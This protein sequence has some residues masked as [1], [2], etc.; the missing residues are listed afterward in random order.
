MPVGGDGRALSAA[1]MCLSDNIGCTRSRP[2]RLGGR[3]GTMAWPRSRG[4]DSDDHRPP[5]QQ[6]PLAARAVAARRA[7]PALRDQA[8]PARPEDDARAA[9]AAPGASARQ[10][11]GDHRR[12]R[13][14]WPSPA[15]SSSTWSS[16]TA[17]AR[18]APR[19]G[20]PERLRYTYW[21]HYAEGS[22]MPPLLLKLVFDRVAIAPMPFFVKPIARGI[23]EQGDGDVRRAEHL[24][25]TSTSWRPS[26]R[27][28]D[29]VR[30]RRVQRGRHP[31]ELSARGLGAR[32]GLDAS[33]AEADG[34]AGAHP[35]AAGL[36]A[37]A[38]KG[39][40]VH[41]PLVAAKSPRAAVS[42]WTHA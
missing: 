4:G 20:T 42:S 39:R 13:R 3:S 11:A 26:W 40:P 32:A 28:S 29:L 21:L 23:V 1:P 35:C 16:A 6:L 36:P 9:R 7:R 14:R 2:A 15:R 30:R 27:S 24:S 41:D 33:R 19:P 34:L 17:A 38:A 8:L 10:V 37:C 31:D 5:P 22:A 18:L 25:A 12:R